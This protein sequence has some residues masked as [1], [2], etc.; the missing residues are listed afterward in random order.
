MSWGVNFALRVSLYEGF[1]LPD[2][3]CYV[4]RVDVK[5]A[6]AFRQ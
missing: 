1:Y 5:P 2:G 6:L 3:L 4:F